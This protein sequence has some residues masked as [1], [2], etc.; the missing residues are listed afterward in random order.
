MDYLASTFLFVWLSFFKLKPFF[1]KVFSLIT[2]YSSAQIFLWGHTR[3]VLL[4]MFFGCCLI[5]FFFLTS[6]RV[7]ALRT[8]Y[9]KFLVTLLPLFLA[10]L[11]AVIPLNRVSSALDSTVYRIR[12]AVSGADKTGSVSGRMYMWGIAWEMFKDKPLL[13]HGFGSYKLLSTDYG[14]RIANEEGPFFGFFAKPYEAHNDYLQWLAEFGIVGFGLLLSVI[15]YIIIWGLKGYRKKTYFEWCS[16]FGLSIILVHGIFEFPMYM[17]PSVAMFGFFSTVLTKDAK[18]LTIN[19]KW[20]YVFLVILIPILMIQTRLVIS[21]GYYAAA[22]G[23]E[24]TNDIVFDA[25][26]DLDNSNR[27]APAN[28]S[29]IS[30]KIDAIFSETEAASLTVSISSVRQEYFTRTRIVKLQEYYQG[31]MDEYFLNYNGFQYNRNDFFLAS[32]VSK[33]IYQ[34]NLIAPPPL[35]YQFEI[36]VFYYNELTKGLRNAPEPYPEL[37][38]EVQNLP[39]FTQERIRN[40]YKYFAALTW[41]LNSPMD[42]YA[43][44]HIANAGRELFDS[45]ERYSLMNQ[46][47]RE[48]LILWIDYGYKNAHH[49]KG[50]DEEYLGFFWNNL[51]LEWLNWKKS[52][53]ILE[54]EDVEYLIDRKIKLTDNLLEKN[55]AFPIEWYLFLKEYFN[56]NNFSENDSIV[57][58]GRDWFVKYLRYYQ[59]N[60]IKLE[61]VK[62]RFE[63]PDISRSLSLYEQEIEWIQSVDYFLRDYP[64]GFI[65]QIEKEY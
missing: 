54:I 61:E 49:M 63:N 62:K 5:L 30:E 14:K 8:N 57:Q 33:N 56:K 4:G 25:L 64:K 10:F 35:S 31:K 15:V 60:V 16:F 45:L 22:L 47:V 51:P 27:V 24:Q 55:P 7:K 44:F 46:E 50:Y 43:Y 58:K 41:N 37:P 39:F 19:P 28:Q 38:S 11:F 9:R 1:W 2:L 26:V 65:S 59:N 42:P 20:R 48:A 36:P 21:N 32:A 17:M 6:A 52:L 23:K 29:E 18:V 12:D 53:G 13:G 40:Q 34:L 3:S